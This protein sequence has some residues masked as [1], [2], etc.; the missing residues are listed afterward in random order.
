VAVWCS[1]FGGHSLAELV[2]RL[3]ADRKAVRCARHA[4]LWQYGQG[5]VA[6]F[7]NAAT[8]QYPAVNPVMGL[9][10][11]PAVTDDRDLPASRTLAREPL[12]AAITG[13][14]SIAETWDKDNHGR[15]GTP[16]NQHPPRHT[17]PR[18]RLRS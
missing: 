14:A 17:T 13:L 18:P 3:L 7:A 6:D 11:A 5:I 8:N 10:T 1:L 15:E 12:A 16:R 4:P 2:E 9:T